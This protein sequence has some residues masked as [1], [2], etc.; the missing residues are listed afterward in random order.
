MIK[1]TSI[2]FLFFLFSLRPAPY[3][4]HPN[5]CAYA[6]E[7]EP[8]RLER[9][10]GAGKTYSGS[11]KLINPSDLAVDILVS[12]G[13]YRYVFSEGTVPP[14]D[15]RKALPFCRDWFEFEKTKFRLDPR[16]SAEVKF[17]IKVPKDAK[18]EHLCAVIFDEKNSLK[19]I[20]AGQETGNARVQLTP[21][22]SIPI[23]ISIKG[24]EEISA[25]IKE[26]TIASVPQKDG[27]M[28][29]ISLENTGNIHI[30]PFGTFII[31]N[32]NGDVVKNLPIGKI[33]PI[34]P[35]YKEII[36]L[37]CPKLPAG[38]YSAVATVEI[39]KD[40]II[41]KKTGFEFRPEND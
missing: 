24:N 39:S 27:A 32:Q 14:Q 25:E 34:F 40:K 31:F 6:V 36:P 29:N 20:K 1:V 4:L 33:L 21:R 22:F 7:I 41:Q 18:Q 16:E 12:T 5:A 3:T 8:M 23:Y 28:I 2:I 26:I 38:K 30:R 15:S 9:S 13:E 11:F 10:L 19:E 17:L 35:G 37:I